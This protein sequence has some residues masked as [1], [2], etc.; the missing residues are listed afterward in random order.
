MLRPRV[1]EPRRTEYAAKS[2]ESPLGFERCLQAL[3]SQALQSEVCEITAPFFFLLSI[4]IWNFSIAILT[5][6]LVPTSR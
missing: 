6:Q 1:H 5:V 2:S 4:K 3:S